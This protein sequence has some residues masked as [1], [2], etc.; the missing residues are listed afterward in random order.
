MTGAATA[1]RR[2][3]RP[4]RP[5]RPP[6]TP[7]TRSF[8][9]PQEPHS[10]LPTSAQTARRETGGKCQLHAPRCRLDAE[11]G[12]RPAANTASKGGHLRSA[13]AS[14]PHRG[15]RQCSC[16]SGCCRTGFEER[17]SLMTLPPAGVLDARLPTV[18]FAAAAASDMLPPPQASASLPG[19]G[20]GNA[21]A[22]RKR[23][24]FIVFFSAEFFSSKCQ[25]AEN[26]RAD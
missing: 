10:R 25:E 1:A 9:S 14:A 6:A 8:R 5:H 18:A 12:T 3:A 2:V 7:S 16:A 24:A 4:H 22:K 26:P 20:V 23:T 15:H 21:S 13:S 11:R 19:S 17:R